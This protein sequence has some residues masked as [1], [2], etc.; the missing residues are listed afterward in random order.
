M[1]F[2]FPNKTLDVNDFWDFI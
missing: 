2:L 1:A